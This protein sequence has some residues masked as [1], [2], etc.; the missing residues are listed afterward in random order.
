ME[1]VPYTLLL[2]ERVWGRGVPTWPTQGEALPPLLGRY[3]S[4]LLTLHINSLYEETHRITAVSQIFNTHLS[5]RIDKSTSPELLASLAPYPV[6][7][8]KLQVF[9]RAFSQQPFHH[10]YS[11]P[12]TNLAALVNLDSNLSQR[13]KLNC[14]EL[15]D[16]TIGVAPA[17]RTRIRENI[18]IRPTQRMF[19]NTYHILRLPALSR[20]TAF[21][22]LNRTIW[23]NNKAYNCNP[24]C[25]QTQTVNDAGKRKP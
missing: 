1:L 9:T 8:H 20:E 11:C 6:Q 2:G 10:K 21:Q 4:I 13:Y 12:Q 25:G 14:R 18:A 22:I 7:Q 5:G 23:T 24:G 3:R 17:Y 16:T 15:L 19:N